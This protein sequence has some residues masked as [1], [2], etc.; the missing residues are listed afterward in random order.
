MLYGVSLRADRGNRRVTLASGGACRFKH[1][2]LGMIFALDFFVR[3]F[4]PTRRACPCLIV[5]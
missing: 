2:A 5:G 3:Q 1:S 4:G